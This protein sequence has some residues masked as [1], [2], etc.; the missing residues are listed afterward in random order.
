MVRSF[1][2]PAAEDE[3]DLNKVIFNIEYYKSLKEGYL[4]ALNGLLTSEEKSALITGAKTIVYNQ[5]IRFLSDYLNSDIY[6]SLEYEDQNLNRAK[7]QLHLF[8]QIINL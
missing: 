1:C 8:L 4:S 5:F 3:A 6:Y 7:V 2:N